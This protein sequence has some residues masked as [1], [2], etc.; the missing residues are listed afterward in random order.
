MRPTRWPP[1]PRLAGE[2]GR[3]RWRVPAI[4][5]SGFAGVV[6][7]STPPRGFSLSFGHILLGLAPL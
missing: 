5:G 7:F 4:D 2:P 1:R 3:C 6:F